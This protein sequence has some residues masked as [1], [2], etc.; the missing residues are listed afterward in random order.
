MLRWGLLIGWIACI[1]LAIRWFPETSEA[2][3]R[4]HVLWLL[5]L[6]WSLA[7]LTGPFV[8]DHHAV[9]PQSRDWMTAGQYSAIALLFAVAVASAARARGARPCALAIGLA[10]LIPA[11]AF[12]S[13]SVTIIDPGS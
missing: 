10:N 9:S 3:R 13:V 6:P 5:V 12:V 8:I 11:Y 4:L 1:V 2:R 7:I